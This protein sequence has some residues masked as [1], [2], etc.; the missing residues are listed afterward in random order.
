MYWRF[1]K[2]WGNVQSFLP[3]IQFQLHCRSWGICCHHQKR[4]W[5]R[6]T[7]QTKRSDQ[8]IGPIDLHPPSRLH[9]NILQ[10]HWN[11]RKNSWW[12]SSRWIRSG[13]NIYFSSPWKWC[14][15]KVFSKKKLSLV[16]CLNDARKSQSCRGMSININMSQWSKDFSRFSKMKMLS[17]LWSLINFYL[18][19][20]WTFELS[21]ILERRRGRRR[22]SRLT[23]FGLH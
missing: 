8:R 16:V 14:F 23:K 20:K 19:W 18:L 15:I 22:T 5:Q 21:G 1:T 10:Q 7:W 13:T 4:N 11:W 6:S 12:W 17:A 3:N 2:F 9:E